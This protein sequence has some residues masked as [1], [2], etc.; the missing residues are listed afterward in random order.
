M[1]GS[2]SGLIAGPPH[3]LIERFEEKFRKSPDLFR[4]PGRVNLIGEHTDYNAGLVLPMAIELACYAAAAPNRD[5]MLR[6][7]SRNL[8]LAR[9]WPVASLTHF[10]PQHDWTDY[11]VGIAREMRL[12]RGYD[13]MVES[14][15][16]L[17]SGLSSSAAL[18]ISIA[19]ALGWKGE[20]PSLQL[21]LLCQRAENSFLGIPCGIMDQYASIFGCKGS[22]VKLDCRSLHGEQVHLPPGIALVAVNSRVQHALAQ[23]AYRARVEECAAA[24]AAMGMK[25]LRDAKLS[26]LRLITD[27]RLQRRARHVLSENHRVVSF[28]AAAEEGDPRDMGRWMNESHRSLRDDY[29]VSCTEVDFLVDTAIGI[30]GVWGARMTGGGFGGCTINLM[31]PSQVEEFERIVSREYYGAFGLE[32]LFYRVTAAGG[33]AKIS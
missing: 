22:A 2:P 20:L 6:V 10:T 9:E 5:C 3:G 27:G 16:P 26:Q 18:E 19:M 33:A 12:D 23:S 1:A 8:G 30:E 31:E 13:V 21:A 28:V 25:T 29:E 24:A 4:A 32:P 14:T 17:G 11:I 7:H 15:V